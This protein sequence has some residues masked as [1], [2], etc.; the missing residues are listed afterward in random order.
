MNPDSLI[1]MIPSGV[2]VKFS[3]SVTKCLYLSVNQRFILRCHLDFRVFYL[4][5]QFLEE[6]ALI[7]ILLIVASCERLSIRNRIMPVLGRWCRFQSYR[8]R[9]N[10][11][12]SVTGLCRYQVSGAV[13]KPYR[14]RVNAWQSVTESCRYQVSGAV[15][16]PYRHRVNA[17]QSVTELCRY[18]VSGAV[19]K[20]YRHRVNP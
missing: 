9:V 11:C 18:Q 13:L 14:Y 8:H 4:F 17:C 3:S 5:T 10:A 1:E 12:P 16:T 20:S 19:F 6:G 7:R 2:Y 15:F